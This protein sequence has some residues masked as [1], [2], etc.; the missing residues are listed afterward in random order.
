M[1]QLSLYIDKDTLNKIE[2]AAKNEKKSISKW[3]CNR[4]RQSLINTWPDD[5][6]QLFG[7]IKDDSFKRPE[8]LSYNNDLPREKV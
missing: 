8:Q 3:V 7:S 6:F 5:F 4:L 1:P 2:K